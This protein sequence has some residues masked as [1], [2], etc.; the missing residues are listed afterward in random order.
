MLQLTWSSSSNT[1]LYKI[2]GRLIATLSFIKE[3]RYNFYIKDT[4]T[5]YGFEVLYIAFGKSLRLWY[6]DFVVSIEVA[7]T[8]CVMN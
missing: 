3:M 1:K 8:H 6:V 2:C 5:L 4:C 7:I